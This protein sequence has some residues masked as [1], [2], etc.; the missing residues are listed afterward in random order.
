V[1]RATTRVVICSTIREELE[2]VRHDDHR[3]PSGRG[4]FLDGMDELTA[5]ARRQLTAAKV[6]REVAED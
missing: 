5:G 4:R 1:N 3:A 6:A 2:R